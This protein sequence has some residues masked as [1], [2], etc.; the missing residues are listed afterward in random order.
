[1]GTTTS[2]QISG[3]LGLKVLCERCEK[4]HE[5]SPT[6]MLMVIRALQL[7]DLQKVTGKGVENLCLADTFTPSTMEE[8]QPR[9][10][11]KTVVQIDERRW[12]D[13]RWT[14]MV[15]A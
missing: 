4:A 1:M 3:E 9:F 6:A 5:L 14:R 13:K 15:A 8:W 2:L 11:S 12:K 7:G 10:D